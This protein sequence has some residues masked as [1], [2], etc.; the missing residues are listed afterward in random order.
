[1]NSLR[2]RRTATGTSEPSPAFHFHFLL[3]AHLLLWSTN[4]K[5]WPGSGYSLL[6]WE[7]ARGWGGRGPLCP[8]CNHP[9]QAQNRGESARQTLGLCELTLAGLCWLGEGQGL[10]SEKG[11]ALPPNPL[12]NLRSPEPAIKACGIC[13]KVSIQ[14]SALCLQHRKL[15]TGHR[16]R[17]LRRFPQS[18]RENVKQ[19]IFQ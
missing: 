14:E 2:N 1:M 8:F 12:Q 13:P 4:S 5:A 11:T 9:S 18:G 7:M 19:E 16:G 3:V 6:L 15:T 17:T 10:G